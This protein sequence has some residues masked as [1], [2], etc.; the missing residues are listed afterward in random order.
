MLYVRQ[1]CKSVCVFRLV[2]HTE[3]ERREIPQDS[4]LNLKPIISS[5]ITHLLSI[6]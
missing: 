6:M 3:K 4:F 2:F 5:L 1:T